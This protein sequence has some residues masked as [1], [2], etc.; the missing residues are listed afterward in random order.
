MKKIIAMV[1]VILVMSLTVMAQAEVKVVGTNVLEWDDATCYYIT[2]EYHDGTTE[3]VEVDEN[4]YKGI[5]EDLE[6]AEEE[7]NNRWYVKA[8]KWIIGAWDVVTFWN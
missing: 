3:V 1:M 5:L 6:A 8:Q 7:H 2:V 4:S